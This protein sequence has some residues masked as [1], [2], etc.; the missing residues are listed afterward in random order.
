MWAY[1]KRREAAPCLERQ[2]PSRPPAIQ[3]SFAVANDTFSTGIVQTSVTIKIADARNSTMFP[4]S[5]GTT[6]TA[7]PASRMPNGFFRE[8]KERRG[9][10]ES[11]GIARTAL[12]QLMVSEPVRL[13]WRSW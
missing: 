4:K 9:P 2:F 8:E 3:T 7:D 11:L 10:E 6:M 13:V 1:R 12:L 5:R